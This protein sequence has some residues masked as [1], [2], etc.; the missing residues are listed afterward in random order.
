M[1]R[2]AGKTVSE[3]DP[4]VSE[5]IDFANYYALSAVSLDLERQ[6]SPVGVVV[7]VP[8]WNFPYAIPAGAICAALVAVNTVFFKS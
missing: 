2:D 4:E 1:S 3:A 8:P 7:V 5:A 6:S